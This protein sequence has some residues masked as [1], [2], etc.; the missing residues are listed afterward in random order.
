MKIL[1]ISHNDKYGAGNAALKILNCL[2]TENNNVNLLVLKKYSS[3]E[4]VIEYS[5]NLSQKIKNFFNISINKIF[6][7]TFK[8]IFY[9]SSIDLL[10]LNI[11]K[12]INDSDFDLIQIIWPQRFMSFS[13]I[14]K[15]NKKIIWRMSDYWMLFG[16][17]H[18]PTNLK[19]INK[20]ELYK[21]HRLIYKFEYFLYIRKIK[22]INCLNGI[23]TPSN[24]LRDKLIENLDFKNIPITQINTPI[25]NINFYPKNIN[26][27][28]NEVNLDPSKDYILFISASDDKN[29]RKGLYYFKKLVFSSNSKKISFIKVGSY[30]KINDN[31]IKNKIINFGHINDSHIMNNIYNSC[32]VTFIPSIIDNSPQVAIESLS[33][34]TPVIASK[35]SGLNDI[36]DNNYVKI[37]DKFNENKILKIIKNLIDNFSTNKISKNSISSSAIKLHH[38]KVINQKLMNFYNSIN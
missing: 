19:L 22:I 15:I 1:I 6:N 7:L 38:Y 33:A 31:K 3:S 27:S 30:L 4:D 14:S 8:N 11:H 9:F 13:D 24:M 18:Y 37:F 29:D 20:L 10:S 35:N 34:G 16:S 36:Y 23:I 28:K 25:D 12:F 32:A 5:L 17:I 26:L 21:D 2:K